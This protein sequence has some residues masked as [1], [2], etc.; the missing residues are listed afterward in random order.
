MDSNNLSYIFARKGGGGEVFGQ[1][2]VR[3]QFLLPN[4]QNNCAYHTLHAD[5]LYFTPPPLMCKYIAQICF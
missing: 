2:E 4:M 1:F 3:K 5:P